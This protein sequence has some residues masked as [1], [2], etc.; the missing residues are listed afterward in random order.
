M[1]H[2]V[3]AVIKIEPATER[4]DSLKIMKNLKNRFSGEDIIVYE[5]YDD[6]IEIVDQKRLVDLFIAE[7]AI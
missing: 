2:L 6:C 1:E 3:D 4:G 5:L 7:T